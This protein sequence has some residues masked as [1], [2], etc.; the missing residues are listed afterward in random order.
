MFDPQAI[1]DSMG[2]EELKLL[3]AATEKK[4]S[5][6]GEDAAFGDI[7]LIKSLVPEG[8]RYLSSE[9]LDMACAAFEIWR[10]EAKTPLQNRSRARLWLAFL[11]LRYGALRLGE[12]LALDD[13]KDIRPARCL[14]LVRGAH[15]RQILLPA[16]VMEKIAALLASPMFYGLRGEVL[17]LDQGYLRRKFYQRAKV[18]GLPNS[19]FNPRVM[20]QSRGLELLRQGM[21][22]QVVQSCLGLPSLPQSANY[23]ELS[24][25]AVTRI[26]HYCINREIK[27]KTSARNA[28][29]GK[30]SAIKSDGLLA[31]VEIKTLS[32]LCIVSVITEQS[33]ESLGLAEGGVVTAAIKAPW[34]IIC[35]E[36]EAAQSS[37]RNKFPGKVTSVKTGEIACE[38][39]TELADGSMVSSIVTRESIENLELAP[40]REVLVLFKAFAVILNV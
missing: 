11:L 18:C 3:A 27:M 34:V 29:T 35:T 16:P 28:F 40:G 6:Y 15:A 19:L 25:D 5:G 13:V 26:M 4:L 14:V 38:V 7:G 39:N 17:K 10:A 36:A 1:I 32:G 31:E 12:V 24:S 20:R 33:R 9:E 23:L 2:R 22:L 30:I 37:A 8:A 21:P